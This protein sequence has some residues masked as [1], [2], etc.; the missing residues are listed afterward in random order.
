MVAKDLLDIATNHKAD[1]EYLTGGHFEASIVLRAPA[2]SRCSSRPSFPRGTFSQLPW[3]AKSSTQSGSRS[4]SSP[5]RSPGATQDREPVPGKGVGEA[6]DGL[7]DRP[8][9]KGSDEPLLG[10]LPW[11]VLW[12]VGQLFAPAGALK[13]IN[14]KL[15]VPTT[16][17][18]VWKWQA[19]SLVLAA[20]NVPA[21]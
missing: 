7:L 21:F 11:V 20:M 17:I 6:V 9:H 5:S 13:G 10:D 1:H 12:A 8:E 19:Q 2:S 14:V 15:M 3:L 4:S 18:W 16:W